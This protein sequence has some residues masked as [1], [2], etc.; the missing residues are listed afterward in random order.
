ML[1][2]SKEAEF[3]NAFFSTDAKWSKDTFEVTRIKNAQSSKW[4]LV[5]FQVLL[6]VTFFQ[7]FG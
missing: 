7:E 2:V 4:T 6:N 1:V 3:L 5:S